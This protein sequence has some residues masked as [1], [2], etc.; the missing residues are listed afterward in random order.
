MKKIY[1]AGSIRGGRH[2]AALYD[3]VSGRASAFRRGKKAN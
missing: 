1:F 2:D 3:K